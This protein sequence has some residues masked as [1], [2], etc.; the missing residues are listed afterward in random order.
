MEHTGWTKATRG[1]EAC[2]QVHF[3]NIGSTGI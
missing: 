3:A 2:V 1:G